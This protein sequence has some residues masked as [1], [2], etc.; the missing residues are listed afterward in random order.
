MSARKLE[1]LNSGPKEL[2]RKAVRETSPIMIRITSKLVVIGTPIAYDT[3]FNVVMK[4]VTEIRTDT[5]GLKHRKERGNI[6]VR[7]KAAQVFV[8]N[9]SIALKE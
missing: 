7:G 8:G 2:L 5:K 4:N 3:S 9:P 1:N 6:F